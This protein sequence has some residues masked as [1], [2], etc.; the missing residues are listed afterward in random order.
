MTLSPAKYLILPLFAALAGCAGPAAPPPEASLPLDEAVRR[1]LDG[2]ASRAEE[3]VFKDGRRVWYIACQ[4]NDSYCAE[5]AMRQCPRG[6]GVVSDEQVASIRLDQRVGAG[7]ASLPVV[8]GQ[9]L[10]ELIVECRT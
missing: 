10:F 3:V 2:E 1:F 9:N 6:H 5:E 7:G 4:Y 8:S